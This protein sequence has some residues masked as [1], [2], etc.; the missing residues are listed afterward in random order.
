MINQPGK[1]CK[2]AVDKRLQAQSFLHYPGA[3]RPWDLCYFH[4]DVEMQ[5][6]KDDDTMPPLSLA[7][8][9]NLLNNFFK[10]IGV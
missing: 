4:F 6:E 9:S 3:R 1:D 8:Y 5:Q 10:Y 7:I 2:Q